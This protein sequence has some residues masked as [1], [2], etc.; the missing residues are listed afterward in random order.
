[1]SLLVSGFTTI[2]LCALVAFIQYALPCQASDIGNDSALQMAVTVGS[3]AELADTLAVKL[4][5]TNKSSKAVS[6]P[7]LESA[8]VKIAV[9][10][11]PEGAQWE[12]VHGGPFRSVR[13]RSGK[14][15]R[16][17]FLEIQQSTIELDPNEDTEW[18]FDLA[19]TFGIRLHPG[20]YT[21]TVEYED[22]ISAESR[23]QIAVNEAKSVPALIRL[24]ENGDAATKVW[25]RNSLFI[26][27]G[28]PEWEIRTGD[29]EAQL[30]ERLKDL[31]TWW[32]A[33][34]LHLKLEGTRLVPK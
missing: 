20:D 21:L 24:I 28:Y 3:H 18:T 6:I 34:Q 33:K 15:E 19:Q 1:M 9:R 12:V 14:S 17:A 31:R 5:L 23:I 29:T 2:S 32:S 7:A 26:L 10:Q 8:L 27:T 13:Q 25:A 4:S 11:I 16:I 22:G 30:K